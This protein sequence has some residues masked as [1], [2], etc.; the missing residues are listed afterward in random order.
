[1][2]K[3]HAS[4]PE[5]K[6]VAAKLSSTSSSIATSSSKAKA[7]VASAPINPR[8]P[9]AATLK[10]QA[11]SV[12][13]KI[14]KSSTAI[15]AKST[16]AQNRAVVVAKSASQ[17]GPLASPNWSTVGAKTAVRTPAV[18]AAPTR[19]SS[20]T[21]NPRPASAPRPTPARPQAVPVRPKP[22]P[23]VVS[24]KTP[25]PAAPSAAHLAREGFEWA[26][27]GIETYGAVTEGTGVVVERTRAAVSEAER[28]AAAARVENGRPV[29]AA[30]QELR[31][32]RTRLNELERQRARAGGVRSRTSTQPG[33][34]ND[35][36]AGA[37]AAVADAQRARAAAAA[38]AF[39]ANKP[40][41][42]LRMRDAV[43]PIA[44]SARP[45]IRTVGPTI[46]ALGN[47]GSVVVKGTAIVEAGLLTYDTWTN[48]ATRSTIGRGVET[49]VAGAV[50]VALARNPYGAAAD[51]IA[52]VVDAGLWAAGSKARVGS[53]TTA[54]ANLARIVPV[55]IEDAVYGDTKGLRRLQ[56]SLVNDRD[57]LNQ[58]AGHAAGGVADT[59][60][61]VSA[62]AR[63]VNDTKRLNA[64]VNTI[65]RRS[66]VLGALAE[67]TV[68]A[69][70]AI[71]AVNREVLSTAVSG[72]RA[73][74]TVGTQAWRAASQAPATVRRE[75]ARVGGA[76]V[77]TG[78][79]AVATTRRAV[80]TV[81]AAVGGNSTA[82]AQVVRAIQSVPGGRY[83][84]AAARTGVQTVR[85]G[86]ATVRATGTRAINALT[87][88]LPNPRALFGF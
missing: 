38:A 2:T 10:H 36:V 5:L 28:A 66:P 49:A 46:R 59:V 4:A 37:R 83:V 41:A 21:T 76:V 12:T 61:G 57:T 65:R 7:A 86:I 44:R 27:P 11:V 87:N 47:A 82:R 64:T 72:A 60:D 78:R 15:A 20:A 58:W 79:A 62:V 84:V 14:A 77:R 22:V 81:S 30:S 51:G 13:A 33:G 42:L 63:F 74:R 26:K 48:G 53:P 3:L 40:S 39:E 16:E 17:V 18:P 70:R 32:A 75:V 69:G 55:G 71:V 31:A 8:D 1:M 25:A 45:M 6:K 34:F 29:T 73:V 85:R 54:A 19:T 68:T 9:G 43:R 35:R 88:M 23:P 80:T 52:A 67:G 24:R 56:S 50:K